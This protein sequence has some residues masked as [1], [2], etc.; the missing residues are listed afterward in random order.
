MKE[1]LFRVSLFI[2]LL[3]LVLLSACSSDDDVQSSP[4]PHR[5]SV[6]ATQPS[7]RM[8]FDSSGAG[9]WQEGD[10]IGIESG[11]DNRF[12][13]FT[14]SSGAGAATATFTGEVS[15]EVKNGAIVLYPYSDK[16]KVDYTALTLTFA[17]PS[18]YTYDKVD[19]DYSQTDGNSFNMPMY[20]L[21]E[22]NS[23]TGQCTVSFHNIGSVIAVKIERMF[24][25]EGSI[26]VTAE[27]PICGT[28]E[29]H[30]DDD[31]DDFSYASD[32]TNEVTINYQ[33]AEIGKP[34]VFYV[35][36]L[37]GSYKVKV[38]VVEKNRNNSEYTS[39]TSSFTL[40]REHIK[41]LKVKHDYSTTY[42]GISVVDFGGNVLWADRNVG[43]S[44]YKDTGNYYAWGETEPKE[45]YTE[46]SYTFTGTEI[47][48]AHDAATANWG[49]PW[50]M[51]TA[52]EIKNLINN[53]TSQEVYFYNQFC[54][55]TN[56]STKKYIYLPCVGY[57][58]SNTSYKKRYAQFWSSTKVED[59][60]ASN[61]KVYCY[62]N[63]QS[64]DIYS[65]Y[66]WYGMTVRPVIPIHEMKP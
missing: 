33:N 10:V 58:A 6:I 5:V 64:T 3:F 43:A 8:G 27:S 54:K 15:E 65:D 9:Y 1:R 31:T 52:D 40:E 12:V 38:K 60:S 42:N 44:S 30:E 59:W 4:A 46:D 45:M 49:L 7:T 53:S 34:G 22:K 21:V 41:R 35:P 57:R 16:L 18:T 23:D 39:G 20:A 26:V 50:R 2:A 14:L 48:A 37:A 63:S 11:A 24:S 56:N 55:L 62:S 19:T 13:P 61:N 51:P 32:A 17:L 66:C 25:T 36:V 47:D 29:L 28:V